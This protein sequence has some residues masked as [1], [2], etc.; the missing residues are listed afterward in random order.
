VAE[1]IEGIHAPYHTE[2]ASLL[3]QERERWGAVLLID[4]HS[5]PPLPRINGQNA[6]SIV[7]GDRFGA[8]CNGAL[9]AECFSHF[10]A[11]A[12]LAA[13]N[14]PYAG[15]LRWTIMVRPATGFMRC[16]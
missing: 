8:S 3:S 10:A 1:R 12:V 13:H 7:V 9:V 15:D 6:A 2:L 16:S 4:L 5:M 11:C 14:R